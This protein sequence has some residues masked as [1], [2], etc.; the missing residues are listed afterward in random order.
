[1]FWFTAFAFGPCF[2]FGFHWKQP[3]KPS[4]LG[5]F[6]LQECHGY[7]FAKSLML[8]NIFGWIVKASV[9]IG[10]IWRWCIGVAGLTVVATIVHI[11]AMMMTSDCIQIIKRR[12]KNSCNKIEDP[13]V[14][15]QLQVFKRLTHS[16][17]QDCLC[18]F[19]SFNCNFILK[20]GLIGNF[21][22]S[23]K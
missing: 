8:Q 1:M 12:L 3:W 23:F 19:R 21:R 11:I 13:N 4:L 2:V 9:F 16:V 18:F 15:R 22:L 10:N 17:Q 20:C 6:I 7:K 5:Y 14:F